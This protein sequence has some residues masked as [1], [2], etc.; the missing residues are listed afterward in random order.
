MYDNINN[1]NDNNINAL[2]EAPNNYNIGDKKFNYTN[3]TLKITTKYYKKIQNKN[4]IYYDCSKR[5][6][7]CKGKIKYN[8]KE[9]N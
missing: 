5:R 1:S 7:G 6:F 8:L 3:N 4:W 9:K 2:I